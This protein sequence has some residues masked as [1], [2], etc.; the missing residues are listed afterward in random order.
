MPLKFS[1]AAGHLELALES[2]LLSLVGESL[3]SLSDLPFY[4]SS[5][6]EVLHCS[7]SWWN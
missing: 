2:E 7:I 4:P 3:S 1:N 6:S 5:S